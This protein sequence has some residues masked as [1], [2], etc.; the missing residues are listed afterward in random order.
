MFDARSYYGERCL[1]ADLK[2]LKDLGFGFQG[3]ESG[4]S[5]GATP[6]P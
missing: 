3:I 6:M 2:D 5:F 1:N 4:L